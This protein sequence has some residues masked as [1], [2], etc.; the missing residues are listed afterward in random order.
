MKQ[1]NKS[2]YFLMGVLASAVTGTVIAFADAPSV[3]SQTIH[4]VET[5]SFI[6]SPEISNPP[7]Q[8]Q[9]IHWVGNRVYTIKGSMNMATHFVFPETAVDVIVGNKDLWVEEHK[10]NHVFVKPNTNKSEGETSTLTYIGDS[11]TSYEFVLKRVPDSEA[12]PCVIISRNGGLM[13]SNSWSNY[14][15]RDREIIQTLTSQFEHEKM[16]IIRQQQNALDKYRGTIFTNYKWKEAGGW[17]GHNFVS[18]VYDDGRWTYIRVNSDNKGVMSIC[19]CVDGKNIV[20]QFTYD[21]VTKMYRVSGI[22]PKLTL[23]YGRDTV[24]IYRLQT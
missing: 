10:L 7:Q 22:Y 23:T 12:V 24:V 6:S 4:T 19:G 20:L 2:Y 3:P 21:E 11:N 18:D 13:N 14:Q 8:C 16:Q 9:M 17:F 15:N 1:K 5:H